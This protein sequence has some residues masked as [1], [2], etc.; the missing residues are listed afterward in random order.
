MHPRRDLVGSIVRLMNDLVAPFVGQ[1]T[2]ARDGGVPIRKEI[3]IEGFGIGRLQDLLVR[4]F[5]GVKAHGSHGMRH[6]QRTSPAGISGPGI[7]LDPRAVEVH[8]KEP[9]RLPRGANAIF[10]PVVKRVHTARAFEPDV[11]KIRFHDLVRIMKGDPAVH[12]GLGQGSGLGS[13]C[14][15]ND[16]FYVPVCVPGESSTSPLNSVNS[17]EKGCLT[18]C[19]LT[20][21]HPVDGR[22]LRGGLPQ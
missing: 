5:R 21:G 3:G 16:H 20:T 14:N 12:V 9:K 17:I 19:Q 11:G 13:V 8:Q 7:G 18:L 2:D 15:L 1:R 6:V 10:Q 4:L 22:H